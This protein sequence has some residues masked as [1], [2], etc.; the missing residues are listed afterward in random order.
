MESKNFLTSKTIIG[1]VVAGLALVGNKYMGLDITGG[2][3]SE[4]SGLVTDVI[5]M[6]GLAFALFGR[7]VATK[8]VK[9]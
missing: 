2:M 3:E 5:G 1:I 6:C 8:K 4:L 9:L 7:I